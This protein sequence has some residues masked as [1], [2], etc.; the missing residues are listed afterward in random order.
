MASINGRRRAGIYQL[1]LT[2]KQFIKQI[3]VAQVGYL[4]YFDD[5]KL[6]TIQGKGKRR[7]FRIELGF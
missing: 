7:F 4:S 6:S 1:Q 5:K 3:Q 2:L